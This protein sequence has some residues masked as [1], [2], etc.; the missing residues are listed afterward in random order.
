MRLLMLMSYTAI[1]GCDRSS[2]D[3][4]NNKGQQENENASLVSAVPKNTETNPQVVSS[5]SAPR[6]LAEVAK[7]IKCGDSSNRVVEAFGEP[8]LV[9]PWGTNVTAMQ[10]FSQWER[11]PHSSNRA[12][13]GFQVRVYTNTVI[14]IE[15]IY[16]IFPKTAN[17]TN[18]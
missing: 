4:P 10:Y 14:S 12:F 8:D 2:S 6:S 17:Q 5:T 7:L 13:G 18:R 3:K 15:P 9:S 16:M 11:Q 1:L